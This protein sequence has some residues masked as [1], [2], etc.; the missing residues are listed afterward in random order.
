[1]H[2]R[3]QI[4]DTNGN[5]VP[6]VKVDWSSNRDTSVV[7]FSEVQSLSDSEGR[8]VTS[9][10]SSQ[11]FGVAVT[12]SIP[13]SPSMTEMITFTTDELSEAR[14]SLRL[15]PTTIVAGKEKAVLILVLR[16]KHDNPLTGQRVVPVSDKPGIVFGETK[17]LPE[18]RYQ[19]DVSSTQAQER[20]LSVR[21]NEVPLSFTERLVVSGDGSQGR[22]GAV[23]VN[24]TQMIAGD[25]LGVTY[26]ATIVDHNGNPL[27]GMMVFWQQEG[28]VEG[29]GTLRVRMLTGS[30]ISS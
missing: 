29:G 17:E 7:R 16:D 21:V 19:I 6:G 2:F 3:A 9:V 20:L 28:N 11:A 30:L 24:R 15:H 18:G 22:I 12:A 27:P 4:R 8:A 13:L 10:T 26:N 14:S 25:L 5:P 23:G 1:M